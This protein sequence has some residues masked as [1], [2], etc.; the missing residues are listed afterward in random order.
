[1]AYRLKWRSVGRGNRLLDSGEIDPGFPDHEAALQALNE[2]VNRF[3]S[4]GRN[5]DDS[6]WI[7]RSSDSDLTVLI[8]LEQ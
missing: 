7:Q 4:W 5:D 3:P 1:M 6:W 8:H 2:L